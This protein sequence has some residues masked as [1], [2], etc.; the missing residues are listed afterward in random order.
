[1]LVQFCCRV[2]VLVAAVQMKRCRSRRDKVRAPD[3]QEYR[4]FPWLGPF[5]KPTLLFQRNTLYLFVR[6]GSSTPPN[7]TM[8][9]PLRAWT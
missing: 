5:R 8:V 9:Y 4:V 3:G 1:M 2:L 6:L 7:G